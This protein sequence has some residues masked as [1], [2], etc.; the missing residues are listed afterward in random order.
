M[1]RSFK[2]YD[3]NP[4]LTVADI[5]GDAGY[6]ILNPGAAKCNGEYLLLTGVFHR[7]GGV[8]F[9]LARS[10]NGYDFRFDPEP[11]RMPECGD[12]WVENGVYDPRITQMG[13]DYFIVYN[14]ANNYRGTRLAIMKTRDFVNFTHVSMMSQTNNRNGAL[15]PEKIGGL[16]CCLN[17]PFAGDEKSACGMEM[18]FSP[19]LTFWGKSRALLEPRASHWDG[20]KLGAGAP[21]IRIKEGWLTIYH[22]VVDTCSGSIYSLSAAILDAREPWKVLARSK[23]PVL[24]P[25]M[26]YESTGRVRNVVFTCNALLEND[27]VRM[28]YSAADSVICMA[29]M[30]L[31]DLVQTCFDG[32]HFMMNPDRC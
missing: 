11:V 17:R 7:E 32:Y 22:G 12:G 27:T 28:Y 18:S 30:P 4:I 2:R 10:K 20:L 6:Y 13:D 26:P 24:F 3:K 9:W 25:Q 29:E 5:P 21:P 19:D 1:Q 16:Y 23:S 15:F 8:I 14:S 31:A